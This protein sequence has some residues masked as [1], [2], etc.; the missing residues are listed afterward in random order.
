MSIFLLENETRR[1]IDFYRIFISTVKEEKKKS[2]SPGCKIITSHIKNDEKIIVC[3]K[4]STFI[5]G[6]PFQLI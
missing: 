6:I 1:N 5:Q 4:S 3:Q 2:C